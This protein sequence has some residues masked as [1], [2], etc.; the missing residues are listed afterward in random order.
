MGL[1]T[2]DYGLVIWMLISFGIVLFILKKFAWK[3]ILKIIKDREK[4]IE[5]SLNSAKQA[6]EE[7]KKLEADNKKILAE[8]R[9]ERDALLKDAKM[10]KEKIIKQSE[11]EAKTKANKILENAQTEIENQKRKALDQIKKEVA[12]LSV[13]IAEKILKKELEPASKQKD[14]IDGLIEEIDL[15]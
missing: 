12:F 11:E 8:A 9:A 5:N 10:T 4:T 3:P 6:R 7:M 15:N 13:D 14:Y 1:V 2:P